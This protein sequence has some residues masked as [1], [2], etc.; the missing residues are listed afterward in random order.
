M[1]SFGIFMPNPNETGRTLSR[2]ELLRAGAGA[3][4]SFLLAQRVEAGGKS[5]EIRPFI[6]DYVGRELEI[7]TEV[8]TKVV[9]K[10]QFAFGF[11]LNRDDHLQEVMR[12]I[13]E[14]RGFTLEG[15]PEMLNR[16]P[17]VLAE[18]DPKN[19]I[20]VEVSL[21]GR[22]LLIRAKDPKGFP[23]GS[24]VSVTLPISP[25]PR[26]TYV[27]RTFTE[28]SETRE[29]TVKTPA[30]VGAVYLE[31]GIDDG[32]WNGRFMDFYPQFLGELGIKDM[33]VE[34][35]EVKDPH[36]LIGVPI[37][38][39]LTNEN[40][41]YIFEDVRPGR[42]RVGPRLF[43]GQARTQGNLEVIVGPET[44]LAFGV[45]VGIKREDLPVDLIPKPHRNFLPNIP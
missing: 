31:D 29:R 19:Q 38:T 36:D 3:A 4:G 39:V 42:Y 28:G 12:R 45:L 7:P 10:P 16:S 44:K 6:V 37:S 35:A 34:L 23:A 26:S 11:D 8:F 33:P 5:P 18:D 15:R 22:R 24:Q 20:P 41:V 27:M 17:V 14:V 1:L 25:D 32:R 43:S 2:R 13:D 9:H 30:I 21:E 40:G